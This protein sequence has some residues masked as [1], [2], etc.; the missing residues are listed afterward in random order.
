LSRKAFSSFLFSASFSCQFAA[1]IE[2]TGEATHFFDQLQLTS[3]KFSISTAPA[4][5]SKLAN[6]ACWRLAFQ[7]RLTRFPT[8]PPKPVRNQ[9]K[10]KHL[11]KTKQQPKQA[12]NKKNIFFTHTKFLIFYFFDTPAL[13]HNLQLGYSKVVQN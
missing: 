7:H 11:Q 6:F 8:Y 1:G 3:Q 4:K 10:K 12:P 5:E 9:N 2:Y 13:R